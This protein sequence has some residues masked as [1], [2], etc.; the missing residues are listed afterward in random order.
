M[1]LVGRGAAAKVSV[2]IP[3]RDRPQLLREAIESV[4]A[5]EGP[6]LQFEVIVGDNGSTPQTPAIVAALGAKHVKATRGAGA[7]V[8]RNAALRKATGE[9]IAFLDDDDHWL[10]T[11]L[12]AHL[13]VLKERPDIDAVVGQVISAD[14]KMRPVSEP[15]P[16]KP[17]GEGAELVRHMLGGYFPQIGAVVARRDALADVGAFDETLIGGEDLDWLLRFARRDKLT[18]VQAESVLFRGRPLGA[19]D[20]LQLLRSRFDRRVFL[21]HALPEWRIWR[22]P[23]CF[24]RAYYGT[25]KHYYRYF[26]DAAASRAARGERIAALRT[27][28]YAARVFPLRTLYHL[29]KWRRLRLAFL[30]AILPR[31]RQKRRLRVDPATTNLLLTMAT[32]IHV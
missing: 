12:R 7:S 32:L 21:R 9:F 6:D 5:I 17:P 28:W 8:A 22:T 24:F 15:W 14:H 26:V 2:I 30:G 3:T 27:I 29:V 16:A 20:E 13:E 4:R 1:G 18:V 10:P 25:L 31:R 19:Y 23:S 11:H